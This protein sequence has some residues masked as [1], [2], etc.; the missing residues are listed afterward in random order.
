MSFPVLQKRDED[1]TE[2]GIEGRGTYFATQP[3]RL[4]FRVGHVLGFVH[5]VRVSCV[6]VLRNFL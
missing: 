2:F 6:T 3:T 5:Y 4:T 1:E